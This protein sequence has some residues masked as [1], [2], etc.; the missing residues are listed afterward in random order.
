MTVYFFYSVFLTTY[1]FQILL[2]YDA[3]IRAKT[4]DGWEPLHCACKW[5]SVEAVSLLIQN[6]A[7]INALTKGNITPLHLAASNVNGRRTLELLLWHP[8]IDPT[9]KNDGG[10]TAYD[11]AIRSGPLGALFEILEKSVNIY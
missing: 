3:D 2:S 9:I 5:D 1:L 6:G 4:V 8:H 7:D 11:I 10:D